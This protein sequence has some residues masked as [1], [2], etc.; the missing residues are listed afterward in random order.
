MLH[1][2]TLLW[3]NWLEISQDFFPFVPQLLLKWGLSMA[4]RRGPPTSWTSCSLGNPA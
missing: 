3:G 1:P 4:Q 2:N